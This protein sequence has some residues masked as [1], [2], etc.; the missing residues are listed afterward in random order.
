MATKSSFSIIYSTL[1]MSLQMLT[2]YHLFLSQATKIWRHLLTVL[3]NYQYQKFQLLKP[4]SLK[5]Q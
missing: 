3:T 1:H 4:K 5:R 2:V